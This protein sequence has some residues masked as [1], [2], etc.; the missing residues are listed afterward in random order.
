[1]EPLSSYE[2]SAAGRY[3][4][5]LAAGS[6]A[7]DDVIEELGHEPNGYFWQGV[8]ELLAP[9]LA[10]DV[11][12]DSEGDTFVAFGA[13]QDVMADLGTRMAAVAN[14]AVRLRALVTEAEAD[15]FEF[16]D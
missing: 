3:H 16:D 7:V 10:S 12:Y 2:N 14:D 6:T 9:D 8:A 5:Q 11:D 1:V 13:D 4:L 15:G